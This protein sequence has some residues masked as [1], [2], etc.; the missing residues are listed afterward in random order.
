MYDTYLLNGNLTKIAYPTLCI[1]R[2]EAT[3]AQQAAITAS[4]T[5]T[6]RSCRGR[7]GTSRCIARPHTSPAGFR[8]SMA[9]EF[10]F[11]SGVYPGLHNRGEDVSKNQ[12]RTMRYTR[13]L[14][15]YV[16]EC[17]CVYLVHS[18]VDLCIFANKSRQ[19]SLLEVSVE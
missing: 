19:N 2:P 14:L 11:Q 17:C 13:D 1:T 8:A 6:V 7:L 18:K 12:G 16:L 15:T 5:T 9:P 10:R 3:S 4:T